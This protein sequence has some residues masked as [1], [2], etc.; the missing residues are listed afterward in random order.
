MRRLVLICASLA[1]LAGPSAALALQEAAGDGSL[2]VKNGS[3]P[4][5]TPV[6][7]L[8]ITGAVWGRIGA[9]RIV[10]DDATPNDGVGPEVTGAGP[11][12]DVKDSDTA[13]AWSGAGFKFRAVGGRYTILIYGSGVDVVAFGSGHVTLAGVPD[14]TGDGSYSLNGKLFQSLPGSG[15]KQLVIGAPATIG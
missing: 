6:V 13:R 10:I 7:A 15:A 5:G 11:P 9:G 8:T 12:R 1:T 14:S 3:A 4:V 2:V